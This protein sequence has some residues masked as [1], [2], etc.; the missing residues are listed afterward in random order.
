[1]NIPT[2]TTPRLRLRPFAEGDVEPLHR[3]LGEEGVVR[4]FP[5]PDPPSVDRLHRFVA[6][7]LAHWE[8]HGYGW[9]AVELLGGP[10]Q[11]SGNGP[12][13]VGWNGLTYLP[14]TGE[15]EVA[16]LLAKACWGR[17]LAVEGAQAALH[18]GFETHSLDQIIAV[19][20][21]DN[22]RSIRVIEKLGMAFTGKASYFGMDVLRYVLDRASFATALLSR[23][24]SGWQTT[25]SRVS[26][27][28]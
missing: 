7:L 27:S 9:W 24:T 13:V 11:G 26:P 4:Y 12:E 3:I 6:R 25:D 20:H 17:G 1:M 19:V 2:L 14:E 10:G 21:P 16:Y 28:C 22:Q 18:Y 5:N 23:S 15:T 8:E